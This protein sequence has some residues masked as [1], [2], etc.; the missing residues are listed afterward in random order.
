MS[1]HKSPKQYLG[2]CCDNRLHPSLQAMI[3]FWLCGT[4]W[5]ASSQ[6]TTARS[7]AQRLQKR[8]PKQ[9]FNGLAFLSFWIFPPIGGNRM[10]VRANMFQSILRMHSTSSCSFGSNMR[11]LFVDVCRTA[12]EALAVRHAEQ[13]CQTMSNCSESGRSD[14]TTFLAACRR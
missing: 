2:S 1:W 8:T 3:G 9:L 14:A 6:N 7:L 13:K 12:V 11:T 10:I 5:N 4:L